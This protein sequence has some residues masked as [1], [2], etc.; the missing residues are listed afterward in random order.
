MK[1]CILIKIFSGSSIFTPC[2]V[3]WT[4]R[5]VAKVVASCTSPRSSA[6]EKFLESSASFR[7][8]TSDAKARLNLNF[9]VWIVRICTRPFSSGSPISTCTSKRPGRSNASSIISFLFVIP[10]IK[11]LFSEFTPSILLRSWLTTVSWTPVPLFVDPRFLQIAS[12]SS[13]MMI[14]SPESSPLSFISFSASPNK[15]RM[16]FSDSPTYLDNISGPFTIFGSRARSIF[17]ISRA[18]RVF[19]HPGGP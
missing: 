8:S 1:S 6:P 18:M 10:I 14:C 13:R 7:M 2:L 17:P 16:F 9:F 19:P 12:S 5:F 11:M 15:A 3:Y 4:H